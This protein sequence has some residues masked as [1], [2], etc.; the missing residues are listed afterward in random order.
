MFTHPAWRSDALVSDGPYT[1]ERFA[2]PALVRGPSRC[3]LPNRQRT[4]AATPVPLGA[5]VGPEE[6]FACQAVLEGLPPGAKPPAPGAHDDGAHQGGCP[7]HQVHHAAP[8]DVERPVGP[9]PAAGSEAQ[10]GRGTP[11]V[12]IRNSMRTNMGA[13]GFER[14]NARIYDV[15]VPSTLWA[16]PTHPASKL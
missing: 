5:V 4:R 2:Y 12:G 16:T 1:D 8:R 14:P 10:G 11:S 15:N 3:I 13:Q 9:E 6:L 7:T